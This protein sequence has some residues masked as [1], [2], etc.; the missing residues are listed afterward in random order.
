MSRR[1]TPIT[2]PVP[3]APDQDFPSIAS[4]AAYGGADA[5]AEASLDAPSAPPR[6]DEPLMPWER[7]STTTVAPEWP[8]ADVAELSAAPDTVESSADAPAAPESLGA[9]DDA[10]PSWDDAQHHAGGGA[11]IA[12]ISHAIEEAPLRAPTDASAV[13][14]AEVN[15]IPDRT[16]PVHDEPQASEIDAEIDAP[17]EQR[18]TLDPGMLSNVVD[19]LAADV[20]AAGA[21]ADAHGTAHGGW[22]WDE[23]HG[24]AEPA[25]VE[26]VLPANPM[27]DV[28]VPEEYDDAVYASWGLGDERNEGA[29]QGVSDSPLAAPDAVPNESAVSD[30]A[31]KG[32]SNPWLNELFPGSGPSAQ[33]VDETDTLTEAAAALR[34]A[35]DPDAVRRAGLASALTR[36]A[37][38]VRSGEIDTTSLPPGASEEAIL[39]TT[40]AAILRTHRQA[41]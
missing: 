26:D 30:G 36:L 22:E 17:A 4:P 9:R 5:N 34:A 37:D 6:S 1:V 33:L 40:L 16:W 18:S 24:T 32:W 3:P 12:M 23:P 19:A 31:G 15:R 21:T 7:P 8:V 35:V 2:L 38:R 14:A 29:Y 11:D 27:L 39:A 25:S 13:L 10:A 20:D 41:G 28:P